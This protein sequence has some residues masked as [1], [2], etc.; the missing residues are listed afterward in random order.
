MWSMWIDSG[1]NQYNLKMGGRIM[2]QE[3]QGKVAVVTGGTRGLGYGISKAFLQQGVSVIA[4]YLSNDKKA[5]D[6][7]KSLSEFGNFTTM[8]VDVSNESQMKIVFSKIS[9]LDYLVNCAG[10]SYEDEI[11]K[12]P[13]DQVRAVFETQLFGKI[14]ACRC[15]FPLLVESE[16]PRIVNLASRF[17][18]RP[19]EGAIPLTA[20]EAGIVMFTKNLALE[21]AKYGIKVNC[22]SPSLTINTGSYEAFYTEED[23][24]AVGKT[25]P[26][27]RLG[28]HEDTA[29]AV[30]FLC[31]KSADYI[32]GE[33]LNVNGGILL[34]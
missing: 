12:L 29:N 1:T 17:A 30:L 22:V 15:A 32:V 33:N 24:E 23:A 34:K 6:A 11:L 20:A 14:I 19:L 28:R 31:S 8:K 9:K 21:W 25:N 10:V 13:M 5:Q 4:F 18:A 2:Y 7:E 16:Y 26:S 27:G 3:M